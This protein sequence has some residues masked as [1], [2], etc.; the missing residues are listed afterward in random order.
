MIRG[1]VGPRTLTVK[2]VV[3]RVAKVGDLWADM[4]KRKR[5]LSKP[6][7]RLQREGN[8]GTKERK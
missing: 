6:I 2:N 8:E 7:E 1:E 3:R 5:S 4:R